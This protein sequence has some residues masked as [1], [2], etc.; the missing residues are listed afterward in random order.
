MH[1]YLEEVDHV[2]YKT[3]DVI[4]VT[5]PGQLQT[6][7]LGGFQQSTEVLQRGHRTTPV[8]DPKNNNLTLYI[9]PNDKISKSGNLRTQPT[10]KANLT[11]YIY[12]LMTN[13]VTDINNSR[14][15]LW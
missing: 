9:K 11:S 5:F 7:L 6:F 15:K 13:L 12:N 1:T 8:C 2:M 14:K 4:L 3:R 10:E